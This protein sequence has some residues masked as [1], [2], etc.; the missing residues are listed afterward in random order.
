MTMMQVMFMLGEDI[1]LTE[2]T[3]MNIVDALSDT[4]GVI[5]LIFPIAAVLLA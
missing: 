3:A 2:R 4:G 5:G 1:M